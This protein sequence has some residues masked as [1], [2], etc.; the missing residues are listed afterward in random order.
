MT[1]FFV[2]LPRSEL[3]PTSRSSLSHQNEVPVAIIKVNASLNRRA[4]ALIDMQ[5]GCSSIRS[6]QH[7]SHAKVSPS[8]HCCYGCRLCPRRRHH[9]QLR[10][11]FRIRWSYFYWQTQLALLPVKCRARLRS[12]KNGIT[13]RFGY[14]SE[15]EE[16]PDLLLQLQLCRSV[17][18]AASFPPANPEVDP[19]D[20]WKRLCINADC[21][22]RQKR[23]TDTKEK[24]HLH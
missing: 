21:P 6:I 10:F 7:I 1:Q 22:H 5:S 16:P 14:S 11:I 15:Q 9:H 19:R 24:L 12:R 18:L 23:C 3:K 17:V 20:E 8:F 4:E 13:P 2:N